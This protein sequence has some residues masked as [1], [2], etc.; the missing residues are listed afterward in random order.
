MVFFWKSNEQAECRLNRGCEAQAAAV[1]PSL[2]SLSPCTHLL[3][4]KGN[5]K[6]IFSSLSLFFPLEILSD[7]VV[8]EEQAFLWLRSQNRRKDQGKHWWRDIILIYL[9]VNKSLNKPGVSVQKMCWCVA[10]PCTPAAAAVWEG[11]SSAWRRRCTLCI[12]V[13]HCGCCAQQQQSVAGGA[14]RVRGQGAKPWEWWC[15]LNLIGS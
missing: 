14:R 12:G 4:C 1:L 10:V 11:R 9:S 7:K 2:L 3:S 8:S 15:G 13:H 5:C 6:I